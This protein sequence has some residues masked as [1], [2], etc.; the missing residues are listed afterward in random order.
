MI[1]KLKEQRKKLIDANKNFEQKIKISSNFLE[2]TT[3]IK[4]LKRPQSSLGPLK[5]NMKDQ[6]KAE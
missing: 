1:N 6:K 5:E 2:T 4:N 3:K